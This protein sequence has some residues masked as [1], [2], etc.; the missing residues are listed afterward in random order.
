MYVLGLDGLVV[1][2]ECDEYGCDEYGVDVEFVEFVVG[3]VVDYEC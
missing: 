2:I 1:E 3:E